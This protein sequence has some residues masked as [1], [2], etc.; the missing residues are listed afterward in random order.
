[1]TQAGGT[2]FSRFGFVRDTQ[3]FTQRGSASRSLAY[4]SVRRDSIGTTENYLLERA[5]TVKNSRVANAPT[6][7]TIALLTLH[8][9]QRYETNARKQGKQKQNTKNHTTSSNHFRALVHTFK[10]L[11]FLEAAILNTGLVSFLNRLFSY[12]PVL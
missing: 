12:L 6:G 1:M 10:V 2:S 4:T 7:N 11:S 8:F 9:L 5:C 3:G